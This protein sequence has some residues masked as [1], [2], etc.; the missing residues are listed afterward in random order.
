MSFRILL[1]T[2]HLIPL[3]FILSTCCTRNCYV[4]HKKYVVL[5]K[6]YFTN[7]YVTQQNYVS[8]E[9]ICCGNK[10]NY[11]TSKTETHFD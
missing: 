10:K 8:H 2:T 9:K 4:L 5:T 3:M 11:V 6:R 1:I 7:N